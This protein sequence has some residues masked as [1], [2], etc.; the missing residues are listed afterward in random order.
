MNDNNLCD[1]LDKVSEYVNLGG[2]GQIHHVS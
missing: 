1:V 2:G